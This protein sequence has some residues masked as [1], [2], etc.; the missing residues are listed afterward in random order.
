MPLIDP[1]GGF[2]LGF[3]R[4]FFVGTAGSANAPLL[5][6]EATASSAMAVLVVRGSGRGGCVVFRGGGWSGRSVSR[7]LEGKMGVKVE[8]RTF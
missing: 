6:V 4:G 3:G 8:V 7:D 2:F 5:D 1:V